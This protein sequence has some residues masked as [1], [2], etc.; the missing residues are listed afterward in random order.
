MENNKK[1]LLD[2]IKKMAILEKENSKGV[3]ALPISAVLIHK[4]KG[5]MA[6]DHNIRITK[7]KNNYLKE[8]KEESG[9]YKSHA[10]YIV[11]KRYLDSVDNDDLRDYIIITTI[12]PCIHCIKK[13]LSTEIEKVYYLFHNKKKH[14]HK[15]KKYKELKIDNKMV[16]ELKI[17]SL[18]NNEE[19]LPHA[20]NRNK[21]I[22]RI[23]A[24]L[25]NKKN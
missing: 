7:S 21:A 13:I 12:P 23:K 4:D 9:H 10:E 2:S 15:F 1:I 14:Q 5:I 16:V 6:Y 19:R 11:I 20:M 17:D 18:V 8:F 25:F 3:N 22:K 24:Y